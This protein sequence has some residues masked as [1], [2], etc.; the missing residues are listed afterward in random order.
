MWTG[1]C[2]AFPFPV[3]KPIRSATIIGGSGK[4]FRISLP[5][6]CPTTTFPVGGSCGTEKPS[7][8][9]IPRSAHRELMRGFAKPFR[10]PIRC[11]CRSRRTEAGIIEVF[12][13]NRRDEHWT[14]PTP[15]HSGDIVRSRFSPNEP[16]ILTDMVT[17]GSERM[18]KELPPSEY[19]RQMLDCADWTVERLLRQ[20][21]SRIM[22]AFGYRTEGG[23]I[24]QSALPGQSE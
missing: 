20:G 16:F 3:T 21:D 6:G 19:D 17:W 9:C 4:R 8:T 11:N 1:N 12:R 5:A 13:R 15:F 22:G 14:F 7:S 10:C 23:L 18:M 24:Q 2:C